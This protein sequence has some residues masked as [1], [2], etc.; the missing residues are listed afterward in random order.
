MINMKIK[1][2][3]YNT[4]NKDIICNELPLYL[5]SR[6]NGKNMAVIATSDSEI[7]K[8]QINTVGW[9]APRT[10]ATRLN[11]RGAKIKIEKKISSKIRYKKRKK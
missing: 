5:K 9:L 3:R 11:T 2:S 6:K 8:V 7:S 1:E 4:K 10:G